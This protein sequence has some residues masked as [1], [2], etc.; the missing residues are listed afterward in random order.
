[1]VD[2]VAMAVERKQLGYVFTQDISFSCSQVQTG[3]REE[4]KSHFCP[5][6]DGEGDTGK[7]EVK[8]HLNCCQDTESLEAGH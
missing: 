8:Q 4:V 7:C 6:S 2:S 3:K 1:M 5:L